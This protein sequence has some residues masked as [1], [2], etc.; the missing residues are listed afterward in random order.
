ME[1]SSDA[2]LQEERVE[3]LASVQDAMR[4]GG[5]DPGLRAAAG[6]LLRHLAVTG[7]PCLEDRSLARLSASTAERQFVAPIGGARVGKRW[8]Q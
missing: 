3:V 4:N 8:V 5:R 6:F 1:L 2:T 7:L